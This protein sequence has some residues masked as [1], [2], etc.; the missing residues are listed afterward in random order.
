[1][2]SLPTAIRRA[3]AQHNLSALCAFETYRRMCGGAPPPRVPGADT[4]ARLALRIDCGK[5]VREAAAREYV[6]RWHLASGVTIARDKTQR[7][8]AHVD[9][10]PWRVFGAPHL[11]GM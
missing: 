3:L 5:P 9:H 6:Y 8:G 4:L 2:E 10:A 1:M 11:L 7:L